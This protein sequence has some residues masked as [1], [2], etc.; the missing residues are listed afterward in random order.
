MARKGSQ[1][2]L[3]I[4]KDIWDL[5]EFDNYNEPCFGFFI[6][7]DSRVIIA[8]IHLGTEWQYEFLGN[9]HF[10]EKHRFFLPKNA[11]AYLGEGD[12]YYFTAYLNQS[13]IYVYKVTTAMCQE[14][15][16][17]QLQKLLASL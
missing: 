2:R 13:S 8:D 10:D 4:P 15:Q 14:R 7:Q 16:D 5:V 11:D 6:T 9:C 1:A 17:A 12:C 3:T